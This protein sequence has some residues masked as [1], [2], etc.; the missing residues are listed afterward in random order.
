MR[1]FKTTAACVQAAKEA[2][3]ALWVTDLSQE[4]IPLGRDSVALAAMLPPKVAVV[5]GSEGAGVSAAML[6]AAERRV[7]LPMY[8]FTESFNVSVAAALVLQRL[9]DAAEASRGQ[10]PA[11]ELAKL[12]LAWYVELAR[13]EEQRLAF[14]AFAESGGVLPYQ[15]TRRPEAHRAEQRAD[16]RRRAAWECD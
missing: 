3:R 12:R 8:G 11:A 10:L 16:G 14:V 1:V 2:G 5:V 13:S 9:L 4:A 7:F 6:A 15:D